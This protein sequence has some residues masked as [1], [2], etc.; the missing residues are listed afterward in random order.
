VFGSLARGLALIVA[1]TTG[2]VVVAVQYGRS[3]G[4][5]ALVGLA[6]LPLVAWVWLPRAAHR[7]FRR[8][9]YPRARRRY[10]VLRGISLSAHARAAI[11]VSLAACAI[12]REEFAAALRVL[13]RVDRDA[14]GDAGRAAWLNNR[15]YALVR[16]GGDA[17]AALRACDQAI[18]V[19]PDVAGFHHTRGVALLAL[20]RV[21]EAIRELEHLWEHLAA[22]DTGHEHVLLEAERCY[23]LGVAWEAKGDAAYAADYFQRAH[24]TAPGSRWA[25][26][27]FAR[28]G[29]AGPVS[30]SALEQ[31][32]EA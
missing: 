23:D 14:L 17:E 8:G 15:A 32:L 24:Q 3:A 1:L 21:D 13:T 31:L 10:L 12:G 18:A 6:L 4:L 2:A 11:D 20:G 19:R 9:D 30:E 26:R 25:E 5:A 22:R 7:A 16:S 27:A 28:V 29:P